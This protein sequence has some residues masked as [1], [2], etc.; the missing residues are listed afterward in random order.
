MGFLCYR[1]ALF[2]YTKPGVGECG[3]TVGVVEAAASDN[4]RLW[5]NPGTDMLHIE[6]GRNGRADVRMLDG[7]GRIILARS[8]ITGGL[9]LNSE[10][11]APGLYLVE[12]NSLEGRRT[13]KWV[14]Q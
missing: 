6:I 11:M 8:A 9:T 14:K 12:V 13:L 2:S 10:D 5:P 4:L 7:M 1:D 3:F